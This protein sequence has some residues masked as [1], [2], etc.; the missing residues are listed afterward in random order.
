MIWTS[1]A[2]RRARTLLPVI[3]LASGLAGMVACNSDGDL[4]NVIIPAPTTG[5]VLTFKD[6]SFNFTTLHTFTM[7]DTVIH[8]APVT[9]NA[10][11]ITRQFDATI[12]NQVRQ[13]FLARGY[14]EVA[15]PRVTQP[16]F[17]V[18]VGATATQNYNAWVGYSWFGVWGFFPGWGWY[19]PGFNTSWGIVYPW[20][21]VVGVT[22]YDRG[23]LIVDLIPTVSVN[24]LDKTIRSAWAGVATGLLVNATTTTITNAIDAMFAQS[25]YLTATP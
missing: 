12:L 22:A 8:F 5:V 21:P 11:D 9:G 19:A 3:G 23:T 4:F 13:D 20:F 18:L 25:P 14:T 6:S 7:P 15:D 16:D 10:I 2:G 17:V 1:E 24:P